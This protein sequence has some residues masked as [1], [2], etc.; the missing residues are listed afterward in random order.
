ME[1]EIKTLEVKISE[2]KKR[3]VLLQQKQ[4]NLER[5]IANLSLK[6]LNQESALRNT[7]K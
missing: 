6:I 2:N 7:K 4:T 3:L 1:K 5:E